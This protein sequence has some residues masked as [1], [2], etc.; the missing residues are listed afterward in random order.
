MK[1]I[2]W[3]DKKVYPFQN[4]YAAHADGNLHYVDEGK[5]PVLLFVHGTPEWSFSYRHLI[6]RFAT[7]YRCIALDHLGFGLSDKPQHADYSVQAHAERLE[8]FIQFHN[9]K[10][11]T[12]I[13]G[14]FGAGMVISYALKKIENIRALIFWNS[15][16]WDVMPD[17]HFSTA[18]KTIHTAFGKFLYKKM[19]FPVNY[20]M[21]K[22]YGNKKKFTKEIHHHYKM[23]LNNSENRIATYTIA[24]ELKDAGNFWNNLWME[25][26]KLNSLPILFIWGMKDI[27]VPAYLIDIWK[28]K[29]KDAEIFKIETGGHFIHEEEP[30]SF[31]SA[32]KTFFKN[33]FQS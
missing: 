23:P 30:E 13:S 26:E 19:N 33:K 3:L 11:I 2:S 6:K 32:M 1:N 9:L 31:S 24:K 4:F 22:A 20:I 12:I 25:I 14:D 10:N 5:G 18:A 16:C 8:W 29:L 15:W 28:T 7:S 21:P 27:F 17:K